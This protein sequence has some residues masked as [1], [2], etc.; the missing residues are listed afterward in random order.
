[1]KLARRALAKQG[2]APLQHPVKVGLLDEGPFA[3]VLG[4]QHAHEVQHRGPRAEDPAQLLGVAVD[5]QDIVDLPGQPS[6]VSH[7]ARERR[8]L[9]HARETGGQGTPR[10][11][12]RCRTPPVAART[13]PRPP[14][15]PAAPG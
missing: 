9:F 1:M 13:V 2:V 7:A 14:S 4:L 3:D 11:R 5:D 10:R 8:E 6:E 15:R 12:R